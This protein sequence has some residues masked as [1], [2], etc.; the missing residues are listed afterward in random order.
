MSG[1]IQRID[2]GL[3]IYYQTNKRNDY[4]H[5]DGKGKFAE[6][7]E[8]NGF[9]DDAV[10]EEMQN[11]PDDCMLVDFDEEDGVPFAKTP[12]NVF[13]ILKNC[14]SDS[15]YYSGGAKFEAVKVT[16]QDFICDQDKV[17]NKMNKPG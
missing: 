10:E 3:A 4:F 5:D 16:K 15:N 9:E 7:C 2:D 17:Y 14:Y 12:E 11:D 13:E 6:Y 1:V 8:A